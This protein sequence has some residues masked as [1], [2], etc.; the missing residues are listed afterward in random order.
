MPVRASASIARKIFLIATEESGD[1]LGASLMKVL[2]QRLGDAVR[3][4]GIGGRAMAREGL[5]SLF[6]I[7]Q[8]S[9][10]GLAAVVK[11]LP[12]ILRKIRETAEAV[13]KASPDIL[14]IIDSPDFTHR[15]ARRVR[16]RDP[17]I[18][19]I[20]YVSP[21]V[22]AW[23][24]GRARA[25]CAYVDHVLA[26]LPFEPEAYRRL[27]G[28]P[29]SYVGH[30]LT[31]QIA[32]L[33]PG[34]DEQQ[35]R[36]AP[37]PVLLVLPGSRRS[38]VKH[39]MAVFGAT[40]GLLQAEGMAFELILPTMPHLAEAVR[41]GAANWPVQPRIVIGEQEKRAAFRI[42]RAALPKSGTVT[43]EL[44][45]AGV[46]MVTAYRTGAIEAWILLRVI[47]VS[48]VIL[49]NLVVGEN[50]VPEFLQRDCT[51]EKLSRA[52]RDVLED[53]PLRRRQVEAFAKLDAIMSTGKATPSTRAADIVL[54]A[55]RKARRPN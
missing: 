32:T 26:L 51:P 44:A 52:L 16:A 46:P 41:E 49:A 35:R 2:R 43:L 13:T 45:L 34:A 5:T 53:S 4:E 25:M 37:P 15:V 27:R 19:I 17:A 29:C 30:P 6:P 22:W 24:P 7:E 54:A 8:L 21:S 48:S 36:E 33:R 3:F 50:V 20:D 39:H 12:M 40:L 38:E 9:I 55:M 23:R 10:M 14:V 31:E 1:R 18:P 47:N 28:P 11:Q 42:A